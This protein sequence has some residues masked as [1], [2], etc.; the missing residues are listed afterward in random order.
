M[1]IDKGNTNANVIYFDSIAGIQYPSASGQQGS[2]NQA[3]LLYDIQGTPSIVVITPDKNIAVHQVYPPN[4]TSVVDSVTN[5]GGIPQSCTT[6][7][8][9][10]EE[11]EMLTIGPNPTQG[12][13]YITLNLESDRQLEI[14]IFN[15][16]GQR[17]I[18]YQPK[19]YPSGKHI[20]RNDFSS[21]PEGLYFVQVKD[22]DSIL[23]TKK[24]ILSR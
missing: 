6:D 1:G 4:F 10:E 19:Y 20:L 23:S 12:L 2:G 8:P 14:Q 7:I 18:Y 15:L 22:N 21:I 16:T 5:A 3:H 24:L 13:A 17:I 9:L 11:Q